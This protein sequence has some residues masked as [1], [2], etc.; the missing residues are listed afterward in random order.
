MAK[1][2]EAKG[3][4]DWLFSDHMTPPIQPDEFTAI[5]AFE[6]AQKKG[7]DITIAGIRSKLYRMS[8]AKLLTTREVIFN[9]HKMTAFKKAEGHKSKIFDL[10]G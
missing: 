3:G 5:M 1:K 4:L 6:E 2:I 9:G 7:V 10:P 8:S